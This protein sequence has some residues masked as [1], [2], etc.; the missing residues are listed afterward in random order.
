MSFFFFFVT[1][2]R[3]L[4]CLPLCSPSIYNFLTF[5]SLSCISKSFFKAGSGFNEPKAVML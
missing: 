1:G 3:P 5:L 2:S 4:T